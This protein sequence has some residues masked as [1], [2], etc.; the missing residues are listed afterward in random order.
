MHRSIR[1][2]ALLAAIALLLAAPAPAQSPAGAPP[3]AEFANFAGWQ[4]F[5]EAG[6]G[7]C[8]ALRGIGGG[9]GP[10][11]ARIDATSFYDVGAAMWNHLPKMAERM[12]AMGVQR[13]RLSP[14]DT[15]NLVSFIFT[16]QYFDDSGDPKAGERLFSEKGCLT[17]HQ[18]GGSGGRVGP[19]LDRL[20]GVNSPVI[21]AAAMWNHGPAMAEK[22]RDAGVT[23]P[24]FTGRELQHLI[25]F[26]LATSREPGATTFQV[27]PG[28]PDEGA[29]VFDAKQCD[30]CHQVGNRG[31]AVGP[32]LGGATARTS[33]AGFTARMWN[34][35]PRMWQQM[36]SRGIDV[37]QLT[38]QEAADLVAYLYASAYTGPAGRVPQGRQV[39]QQKACLSCHVIEGKGGRVG[40]ELTGSQAGASPQALVAGMWNHSFGMQHQAQRQNVAWPELSGQ[41]LSDL[42]AYMR[43]LSKARPSR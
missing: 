27:R 2:A 30:S 19:S 31:G 29:R 18:V 11:L 37:P 21:L 6:C 1:P 15:A 24:T 3:P 14:R 7:R 38:G 5:A 36:R 23:R 13:P 25:A 26:V 12:A 34:H 42:A 35:G 4:V 39:V 43:S 33:L 20:K 32:A 28:R 16:A 8:H 10:D 17:C 9:P 41:D 22:M 40:P